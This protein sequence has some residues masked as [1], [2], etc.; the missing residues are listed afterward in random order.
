VLAATRELLRR[1]GYARL[2]YSAV[3]QRADVTRQLL[4]RWWPLK[5]ELVAE[6]VFTMADVTWPTAFP[7]PLDADL[8]RFVLA[9]TDYACREDVRAG[10]VGLMSDPAPSSE[11]PGLQDGLLGPVTASFQALIDAGTD[12]GDVRDGVDVVLTLNTIRGAVIMH[13]LADQT[14]PETIVEHLTELLTWA[15]RAPA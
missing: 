13:L 3:A 9:L 4:Y 11:L 1:D 14:P 7:G 6:A 8:G 10:I 5:N 2:T 12:R 15:L